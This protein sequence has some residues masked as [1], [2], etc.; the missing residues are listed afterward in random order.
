M[1]DRG[2][3]ITI[4]VVG[5]VVMCCLLLSVL[6]T[7][8]RIEETDS[9]T[10]PIDPEMIGID[11]LSGN[12]NGNGGYGPGGGNRIGGGHGGYGP[13]NGPHRNYDTLGFDNTRMDTAENQLMMNMNS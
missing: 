11:I 1:S 13:G 2:L 3:I 10:E 5:L 8:I 7:R 6:W 9:D 12:G 4:I